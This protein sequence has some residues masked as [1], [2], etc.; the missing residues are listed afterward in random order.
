MG[1]VGSEKGGETGLGVVTGKMGEKLVWELREEKKGE[2]PVWEFWAQ[3]RGEI[4]GLGIVSRKKVGSSQFGK[5]L[6]FP[7]RNFSPKK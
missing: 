2:Q 7:N 6:G 4:A 1:V 5:D 3:K